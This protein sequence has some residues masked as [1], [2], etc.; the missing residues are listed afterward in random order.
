M[1]VPRLGYRL[2]DQSTAVQFLA[3]G[4]NVSCLHSIQTGSEVHLA[5]HT[6]GT[7]AVSLG[8]KQQGH[9]AY[10]SRLSSAKVKNGGA[11]HSLHLTS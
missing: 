2:D 7:G 1:L 3:K 6:M 4:R 5:S 8:I 10:N 9:A 11:I